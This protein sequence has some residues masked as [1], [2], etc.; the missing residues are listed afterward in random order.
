MVHAGP[1]LFPEFFDLVLLALDRRVRTVMPQVEEERPVPRRIDQLDRLI[2]EPVGQVFTRLPHSESRHISELSGA[3]AGSA[4][5]VEIRGRRP[6]VGAADVDLEPHRLRGMP[7][8]PHMPL[9]H[10]EG[11]VTGRL[12]NLRYCLLT[13]GQ[14][15][16]RECGQQ[17]L[18]PCRSP[19]RLPPGGHM[20]PCR[21]FPGQDR[22]PGGGTDGHRIG[23]REPHPL[24]CKPVKVRRLM[25][26]RPV[27]GQIG[28]AEIIRQDEHH[29][30]RPR[31][32]PENRPRRQQQQQRENPPPGSPYLHSF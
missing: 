27:A 6:P 25:Q 32:S 26:V 18:V 31:F 12:Q 2:G 19:G 14:V 4:E 30:R 9:A 28:P 7:R 29:I 20:Q 24:P 15:R 13:V 21:M 16:F 22:C 5:G 23:A 8:I 11:P 3:A 1:E 17:G 10:M